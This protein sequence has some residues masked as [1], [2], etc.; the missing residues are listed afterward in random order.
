MKNNDK[1]FSFSKEGVERLKTIANVSST[2]FIQKELFLRDESSTMFLKTMLMDV[3]DDFKM[4]VYNLPSFISIYKLLENPFIDY[5]NLE[6]NG[7]GYIKIHNNM[8]A[9]S[10]GQEFFIFR[11]REPSLMINNLDIQ[12]GGKLKT[13]IMQEPYNTFSMTKDVVGKILKACKIIDATCINI[14]PKG[15]E[16]VQVTLFNPKIQNGNK[17]E[18]EIFEGVE[19]NAP[20]V[21]FNMAVSVFN[22]VDKD[23]EIYEMVYSHFS[24]RK[25]DVN[26]G[27]L[28]CME[29]E[30]GGLGYY[31]SGMNVKIRSF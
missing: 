29:N 15:T 1:T 14:K 7:Q 21:F 22:T 4:G 13:Q 31:T 3:P 9:S 19:I 18:L 27:S 6:S 24:N 23:V 5:S 8:D 11:N 20:D 30:E 26:S 10:I 2:T 28:I 16:S 17:Y 25:D 12:Q